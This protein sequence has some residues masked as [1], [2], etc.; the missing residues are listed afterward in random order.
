MDENNINNLF[1][2]ETDQE[3]AAETTE[4]EVT[5]AAAP[6]ETPIEPAA[7]EDIQTEAPI[8]SAEPKDPDDTLSLDEMPAEE[9]TASRRMARLHTATLPVLTVIQQTHTD[10]LRR[11]CIRRLPMLS[12]A[13]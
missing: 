7:A 9:T 10:M 11:A 4:A 8:E 6:I 13:T 2:N 5:E 3:K 1:D 12:M